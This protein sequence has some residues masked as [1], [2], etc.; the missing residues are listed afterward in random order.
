MFS[1]H[2]TDCAIFML[3]IQ[4]RVGVQGNYPKIGFC[5]VNILYHSSISESYSILE[6]QFGLVSLGFIQSISEID[7]WYK[8]LTVQNPILG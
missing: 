8:I 7:E 3:L 4:A 2:Q 5:T 1:V 6:N